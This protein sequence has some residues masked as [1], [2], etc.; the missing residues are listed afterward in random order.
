MGCGLVRNE[1][2]GEVYPYVGYLV[3][4]YFGQLSLLFRGKVE[5]FPA[6]PVK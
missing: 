4:A 1:G 6:G 5:I 2:Q 3:Y